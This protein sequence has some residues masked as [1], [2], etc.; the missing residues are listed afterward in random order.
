MATVLQTSHLRYHQ[1]IRRTVSQVWPER[2]PAFS[3]RSREYLWAPQPPFAGAAR[4]PAGA[5]WDGPKPI[6]E[7][8]PSITPRET[9]LK[10][11]QKVMLQPTQETGLRSPTCEEHIAD[12][13]R[14]K[15]KQPEEA[16]RTMLRVN[17]KFSPE[18]SLVILFTRLRTRN[19][20]E[21]SLF[22]HSS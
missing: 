15:P 2:V 19:Q 12:P 20:T 3:N 18:L 1:D 16:K 6:C 9:P 13:K 22:R 5:A 14:R 21:C 11:A 7:V 17:H 4:R 10:R 8:S